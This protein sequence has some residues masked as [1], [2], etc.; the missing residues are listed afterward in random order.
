MDLK[1]ETAR[2][3]VGRQAY[4]VRRARGEEIRHGDEEVPAAEFPQI[5][6]R[7]RARLPAA[8]KVGRKLGD[9]SLGEGEGFGGRGL[10]FGERGGGRRRTGGRD[11]RG[12]GPRG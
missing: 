7:S 6:T 9:Q 3:F 12:S 1:I 4:L 11:S 2:T 10:G 8:N 5:G